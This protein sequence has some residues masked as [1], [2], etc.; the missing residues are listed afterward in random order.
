MVSEFE[1]LG[2]EVSANT[3][4]IKKGLEIP[5]DVMIHL[6]FLLEWL[7]GVLC[8]AFFKKWVKIHII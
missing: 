7:W 6:V 2:F 5:P 4:Q 1:D 8:P 3:T